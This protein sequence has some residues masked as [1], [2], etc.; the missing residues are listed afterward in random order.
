[1][2]EDAITYPIPCK[3]LVSLVSTIITPKIVPRLYPLI[4]GEHG[5]GKT[6]LIQL[7][8]NGLKEPNGIVYVD[9]PS[10]FAGETPIKVVQAMQ[11]ALDWTEDPVIDSNKDGC[12]DSF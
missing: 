8:L 6:C 1:M 12:S 9:T 7:A 4:I 3:D 10:I 5:T 11:K 2:F